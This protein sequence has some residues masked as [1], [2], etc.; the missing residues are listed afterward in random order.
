MHLVGRRNL[1]IG[2]AGQGTKMA[3]AA[4]SANSTSDVIVNAHWI[5]KAPNDVMHVYKRYVLCV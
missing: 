4:A 1:E 5:D 2:E 3:F